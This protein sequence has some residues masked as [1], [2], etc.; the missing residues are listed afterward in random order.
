[1]LLKQLNAYH[2]M[3]TYNPVNVEKPDT[4]KLRHLGKGLTSIKIITGVYWIGVPTAGVYVLCGCPEDSVKHMKRT[5]LILETE[6]EGVA[7]ET[8][9][10]A[11][12]LSDT[13]MQNDQF[14][15]LSEFPVLQMLYLQGLI[16]PDHPN[17]T[18]IRPLLIGS[19][20]QVTA[21]KE[22]IYRGNYGLVSEEE[23][24]DAGLSADVAKKQMRLKRK[25][26]FGD[27]KKTE[28]LVDSLIIADQAVEIRNG[29]YVKRL[30]PNVFEFRYGEEN[31]TVDLNLAED[32]TYLPPYDL[33]CHNLQREYFAVVHSGEGD[34]WDTKRPCMGSVLMF[35][36]K[37][38]LIDA[39]PNLSATLTG[40]GIAPGEIE[41][42]FHTH[43]HDDHFVGLLTLMMLDKKIKYFATPVVRASVT[44]K[45]SALMSIDPEDFSAYFDIQDLAYDTWNT[46][47]A[48]EVKPT[49]SPHP[50][51]TNIFKFRAFWKG[52]Y[53]TYAHLADIAGLDTLQGWIT[54]DD[55]QDG[56]SQVDYDKTKEDYLSPANVKKIDIGGG[57][58]HGR[59]RD[60]RDDRSGRIVLA[61]KATPLTKRERAIGS[62]ATFGAVDVLIESNRDYLKIRAQQYLTDIFPKAGEEQKEMILNCPI[63]PFNQG[64]ILFKNDTDNDKLYLLLTGTVEYVDSETGDQK[65][66]ETG[67]LLGDMDILDG[68]NYSGTF[69]TISH[70]Q[71]LEFS[72][73]LYE[74]LKSHT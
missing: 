22:Y 46:I 50:V 44:K 36:G 49:L 39:G 26:A 11:I 24:V 71:A 20:E 33:G 66:L 1:M 10:N 51:E 27:I 18:G 8:G 43:A 57:L 13:L 15:N 32:E 70:I 42:I 64:S 65:T 5:G 67:S 21:Q 23:L 2:A 40:L 34:G 7:F 56:I 35:Q 41:G 3:K 58:I 12:L 59:A 17:N 72:E 47:G 54:D 37:T 16:L 60:F 61:H 31:A 29:V 68:Y 53:R 55:Q 6:K 48:L 9:P 25:F 4:D 30:A 28:E 14:S 38:Y 19:E 62:N 45:L 73:D 52:G 69:R 74:F 63:V